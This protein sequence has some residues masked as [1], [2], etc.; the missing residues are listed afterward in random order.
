M[1]ALKLNCVISE[2][3]DVHAFP[4]R[5]FYYFFLNIL[6]KLNNVLGYIA[7]YTIAQYIY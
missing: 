4:M 2:C 5:S 1:D 3:N 7:E 6:D